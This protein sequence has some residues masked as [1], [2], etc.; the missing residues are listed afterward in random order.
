MTTAP[1]VVRRSRDRVVADPTRL[2]AVRATALLDTP[3]EAAFDRLTRLASIIMEAP[4]ALV[5][6]VDHDRDFWKACVGVPEPFATERE[7]RLAPSFCQHAILSASPLVVRD[8]TADPGFADLPAVKDMGI[9]AYLG[10]PLV[11]EGGDALGSFCVFDT[12]PRDWTQQQ[13]AILTDLAAAAMTEIE[14]RAATRAAKELASQV[15]AKAEEARRVSE[16]L[17]LTNEELTVATDALEDRTAEAEHERHRV[18]SILES[19][20]DAFFAV[21]SRWRITYANS[22]FEELAGAS[23]KELIGK[24]WRAGF[25]ITLAKSTYAEYQRAMVERTVLELVYHDI[26]HEKWYQLR[27]FPTKDGGIAVYLRNVTERKSAQSERDAAFVLA[28]EA[29]AAA[30]E[31]NRAK[32]SFLADM[33]HELRTPLN[34]IAGHVQ[35]IEMGI[36]GPVTEKQVEALARV[37]RAQHHLLGLINDVLNFAKLESGK[38][39][40]DLG[41]VV[42]AE[43]IADLNAMIETQL[44]AKGLTYE[45]LLPTD[46]TTVW[47]DRDKL[48]QILLNLLSN[49]VKFTPAGGH[50]R[51]EVVDRGDASPSQ[52]SIFIR[53]GD[54]GL[55][56]PR[57]KLESVFEPFIQLSDTAAGR[58]QGTGLGLAISRDLA[59]GMGGD[60]RARSEFGVGST[61]TLTLCRVPTESTDSLDRRTYEDRRED[62]RRTGEDRRDD[63]AGAR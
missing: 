37:S 41:L 33:S 11:T 39:P 27:A 19:I 20:T 26:A 4:M 63:E 62:E 25:P 44:A 32:S 46:D 15:Q 3:A 51:V 17:Q 52:E 48:L 16:Q 55:G 2:A 56:I 31:A 42:L 61:F 9:R 59:R 1:T 21:D 36:Y 5:S 50:V 57:D 8:A 10:I 40:Y 35:L 38:V 29:Q 14:L 18:E 43:V 34:A 7:I 58:R 13:I 47:A 60:L 54:N 53:V 24:Q 6:L 12:R 28:Q 45:M 49:A 23:R 22:A 30:E